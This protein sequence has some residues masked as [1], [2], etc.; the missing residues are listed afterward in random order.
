MSLKNFIN[1]FF[2]VNDNGEIS[3]RIFL[4]YKINEFNEQLTK[5]FEK[6]RNLRICCALELDDNNNILHKDFIPC[7]FCSLPLVGSE[8]HQFPFFI[9]SP[10]FEPDSER[11]NLLLDG[12]DL[13]EKTGKIS[14]PGINKMILLRITEIYKD[15]LDYICETNIGKRYFLING[16]NSIPKINFLD[17]IWYKKNFISLMRDILLEY[18]IAWN[19]EDHK[20]LTDVFIPV[21]N[22]Y[23]KEMKKKKAYN[24]ISELNNKRVPSFEESQIFEKIIWK[25]DSRIIFKDIENCIKIIDK[26]KNISNLSDIIKSNIFEW[27]D[28]FLQFIKIFH[29]EYFMNLNCAIIPNMN[30]DFVLLNPNL[31]LSKDVPE[32]MIECM[33]TFGIKWREE[34]LHKNLINFTTGIEHNIKYAE[35]K[36]L[37]Y[38]I[39]EWSDKVLILIHYIPN[40]NNS[41]FQQK[42]DIIYELCSIMFKDK[43]SQ[44][45]DGTKFPKEIYD[46]IDNMVINKIIEKIEE[47]GN[48]C[49]NCSIEFIN[50][51]LSIATKYYPLYINNSIIPNK[52]GKFCKSINLYK[53]DKIPEIFKECLKNCFNHDINEELIDDRIT[54]VDSLKN[55][56]IYD[57]TNILNSYFIKNENYIINK[58]EYL[59]NNRKAAEYL[60]RIIPKKSD[61]L[62]FESQRELF[63]IYEFFTKINNYSEINI[64]ELNDINLWFYSNKYIYDKIREII[65]K[66]DN[67]KSLAESLKENEESTIEKLKEF[68]EFSKIGKIILNQNNNFCKIDEL[69]NEKDWENDS[70]KL[71][72]IA[73]YLDYDVRN[74]LVHKSMG[75]P[76]L[77]N[78]S[79]KDICNKIDEKMFAEY[80]DI[81]NHQNE[82]YKNAAKYLSEYFDEIGEKQAEKLF[83]LTFSIKEAIAYNV[84]YDE[85]IRKDFFELDKAFGINNLSELSKNADAQKVLKTLLNKKRFDSQAISTILKDLETESFVKDNGED[86]KKIQ[87]KSLEEKYGKDGISKLCE[88]SEK[89]KFVLDLIKDE[90][91]FNNFSKYNMDSLKK[92]FKNPKTLN[93]IS[94]GELSDNFLSTSSKITSENKSINI[95]FNSEITKDKP[96]LDF[97]TNSLSPFLQYADDF[98]FGYSNPNKKTGTM[99]EAYIYEVLSNLGKYKNVKWNMLDNTG[100]GK[101]FEYNGK[102]YKIHHDISHHDILV[103]SFDDRKIYVE[104]K[105]SKNNFSSKVPLYLSHRQI[106]EMEQIELPNE[107]V[108]VIVYNIMSQP[109]HFFMTL[110]KN[111]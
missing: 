109:K 19:G 64:E 39:D 94:N 100:Q 89:T 111:I 96:L 28:D 101:D 25:K 37:E 29:Y 97:Y 21:I 18:P 26:C 22:C 49:N 108:L 15:F 4:S 23:D 42:R 106:E 44:K 17:N 52:N 85:K 83:H 55:K 81:S 79:Y 103:E 60:I 13:N 12:K 16:I 110:R 40:D 77:K 50:K 72:K 88:N 53:E 7:L 46:K 75:N 43:M 57:Y 93:S 36:I 31:A 20:K 107:Y 33:E 78:M 87:Y 80:K 102:H 91:F 99:G 48:I 45:K 105:S 61:N 86:E 1:F 71:K 6:E 62:I 34:H 68:I 41:E 38:I 3:K 14:E 9:N 51:F 11:M 8:K 27:I 84:I 63:F 70:E 82:N 95:S 47:F 32:N 69:S 66:H 5:K 30:S 74:E 10:D 76:C 24:Y 56:N 90:E 67:I 58:D 73:L 92:F 98:D 35:S 59:T 54:Y 65:E 104:V 2:K